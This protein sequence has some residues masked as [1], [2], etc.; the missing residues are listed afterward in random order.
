[1]LRLD[2]N[3]TS[4]QIMVTWMSPS[5]PNGV[6]NYNVT[7]S[8]VNLVNGQPPI[9]INQPSAVVTDTM[10]TVNHISVPYS[11]YTVMVFASTSAGNSDTEM[12]TIQTPEAG[13]KQCF[14]T[15][16]IFVYKLCM[17][18][19]ILTISF[20]SY[21]YT[22][23]SVVRDLDPV[24]SPGMY[25]ATSGRYEGTLSINWSEP[26]TPNGIITNYKYAVQ[27]PLPS[28]QVVTMDDTD[29]TSIMIE[30]FLLPAEEYDVIVLAST[31]AGPG[32]SRT[33]TITVP[34][35]G[36]FT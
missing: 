32:P 31:S 26:Q 3:V 11:S 4:D 35:A 2:V 8:A 21:M 24:F 25:N 1:M 17:Y 15:T 27:G 33:L 19:N 28:D 16:P 9:V 7:L 18:S 14:L 13:K 6:V 5:K 12:V 23:P 10:Y 36:R 30:I 34:E 20:L 22:A 29:S